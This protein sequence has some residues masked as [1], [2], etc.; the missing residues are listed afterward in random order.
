[1]REVQKIF[2]GLL[3]YLMT[4]A[5]LNFLPHRQSTVELCFARFGQTQPSFST[6]FAPTFCNP[7]LPAHNLEG[8]S[9]GR[10]VHREHF[11]QLAL[12]HFPGR[13]ERLQD[14]ELSGPQPQRA[15]RI[16]IELG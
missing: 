7:A 8:S 2:P 16:F 14:G 11:A 9:E 15:E 10:T 12:G 1:M 3:P 5:R 13:G 6:V 4:Q